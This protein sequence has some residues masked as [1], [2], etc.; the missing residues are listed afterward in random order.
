MS[1]NPHLCHGEKVRLFSQNY[2][3]EGKEKEDSITE[4]AMVFQEKGGHGTE[5]VSLL[6]QQVPIF[7]SP[8]VF[9]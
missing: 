5:A 8:Q 7:L 4:K 1:T 2:G 6:T 3:R 9:G